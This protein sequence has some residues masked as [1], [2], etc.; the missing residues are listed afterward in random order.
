MTLNEYQK[1]ALKTAHYPH[2]GHNLLNPVLTLVEE[3]GEFAKSMNQVKE[4]TLHLYHREEGLLVAKDLGDILWCVAMIAHEMDMD[5]DTIAK[6]NINKL[7]ERYART[8]S[9]H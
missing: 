5:L 1:S 9:N 4:K 3:T 6:I 2:V 8:S 7:T